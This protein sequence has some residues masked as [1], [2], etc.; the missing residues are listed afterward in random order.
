MVAMLAVL[1][2]LLV[3]PW[4]CPLRTLVA[5]PCPTCGMTRATRLALAGDYRA[6]LAMH[7]LVFVVVPLVAAFLALEMVGYLRSGSW[8][9]SARPRYGRALVVGVAALMFVVWI[10]RFCGAFG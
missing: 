4:P 5:V 2:A 9:A 10:A 8:G 7:P 3:L 1:A 6:A